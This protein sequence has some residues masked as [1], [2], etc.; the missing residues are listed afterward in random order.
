MT[1]ETRKL[2]DDLNSLWAEGDSKDSAATCI[3][4]TVIVRGKPQTRA[5]KPLETGLLMLHILQTEIDAAAAGEPAQHDKGTI[6]RARAL[7]NLAK[8]HGQ[9]EQEK[10]EAEEWQE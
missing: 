7:L 6:A 8:W 9:T 10:A 5:Y 4:E 2:I 1:N 3:R